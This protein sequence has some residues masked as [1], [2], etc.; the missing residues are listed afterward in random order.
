MERQ[1]VEQLS[2]RQRSI[3]KIV[4]AEHVVT[5]QPVGSDAVARK[6]NLGVSPA[7]VRN[8]MAELEERGY[9]YHPH[10]SAGRLP[11]EKGYRYFVESLLEERE[12]A[13]EM[14]LSIRRGFE[15]RESVPDEWVD[16]AAFQLA[17]A[18]RNAALVS[19]PRSQENRLKHLQLVCVN[20]MLALLV[21]VF[22]DSTLRQQFVPFAEAVTQD[23]ASAV[24]NHLNERF[25]G[26]T[27]HGI[28][29][30]DDSLAALETQVVDTVLRIMRQVD[31]R[32]YW[33]LHYDG[34]NYILAQPEFDR[35]ERMRHVLDLFSDRRIL[36]ELMGGAAA[37]DRPRI[38]IGGDE[39][40]AFPLRECS[41]VIGRYGGE[42]DVG[43]VLAVLGPMRMEYDRAISSVRYLASVL[44][45]LL[46][47]LYGW[48]R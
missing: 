30:N 27:A 19:A 26:L 39:N 25:S 10:T 45:E 43:G 35:A 7:T 42:N 44:N 16:V 29:A 22:G 4:V 14:R 23:E 37:D 47:E 15:V 5:A 40:P 3:L 6:L 34:L 32:R 13:S 21:V 28:I 1:S 8:E 38:I 11:S 9:L 36:A 12:L 31:D 46:S 2:E 18:T 24:A 20:E 41:L 17:S 48:K 33:D